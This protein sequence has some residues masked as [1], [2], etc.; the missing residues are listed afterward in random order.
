MAKA[1]RA[2][3]IGAGPAGLTAA[4]EL[5]KTTEVQ[6]IIF[7]ATAA[8]GGI[9]KTVNYRG[10]RID[11]GPHR[12]FSKSDAVMSWWLNIFPQ[13]GAPARDDRLLGRQVELSSQRCQYRLGHP[14]PVIGPAPDPELE[15]EVFLV[16]QRLTRILFLRKFF[17][18]P[19]TLNWNT[20]ANIGA[21]RLLK[22]LGTYVAARVHP[23]RPERS[24]E[25]F[26]I[27]RF[28]AELYRTFFRNYT[29]KV[30]GVPCGAISPEWG[31]QRVKG[32][33]VTKALL[34]ALKSLLPQS[35]SLTQ[36]ST[37]TTLITR[38]LYPKLGPGQLWQAVAR[39]IEE[40]G[41]EIHLG[42]RVV[43]IRAQ[44]DSVT[45]LEVENLAT[46]AHTS[47]EGDYVFSTMP[48]RELVESITPS[49]PSDV[50][51]TARGLC[52]RDFMTVGLLLKRLLLKN[53]TSIPTVGN[54]IPDNWLYVQEPE[55]RLGRIQIFNNWSPYMVAD[56]ATVWVGLEYFCNEGDELWRM[57]D[58]AF[59]RFATGECVTL[60]IAAPHDVLDAT[61]IR[62][63]KAYPA[64][65]GS[66]DRFA[67]IREYVDRFRNLYLIG[68]NG[69]HRY[70]NM[71]HSMLT[72]MAAVE[73]VRRGTPDKS[74]IWG[75]NV[76]GSYH[77]EK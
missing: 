1:Q 36:K 28:G 47:Y 11:L 69:M 55:V 77:E 39:Q 72:A 51:A 56:P 34:H 74:R 17:D 49:P 2:L 9:A 31:A 10:N 29:E 13:Q 22:I 18:Y 38:F 64:Y 16:R 42:R 23:V 40:A 4:Y 37:E 20:M 57:D 52:Y 35:R 27:N 5:L 50:T 21:T 70:N 26:F 60:G 25:D 41:G 73:C 48:V 33:S 71:D 43:G 15:D 76:E 32:L 14:E 30:W 45:G 19:V 7:E 58:D 61:V 62:M 68:R 46:G 65:F 44:R 53:T 24:L 54:I 66:Y 75:V 12:F 63:P 59:A 6:P 67:C 8:I 3:I